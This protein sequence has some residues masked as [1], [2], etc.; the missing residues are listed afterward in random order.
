MLWLTGSGHEKNG[1][2]CIIRGL[3]RFDRLN[4]DAPLKRVAG[5][6]IPN[7]QNL[8]GTIQL[9][10]AARSLPPPSASP[11]SSTSR[12]SSLKGELGGGRSQS[13]GRRLEATETVAQLHIYGL[14]VFQSSTASV[15][16]GF[17]PI[18][19]NQIGITY[20]IEES[21][22]DSL[23]QRFTTLDE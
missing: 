19:T 10:L 3:V 5:L 21:E 13:A 12:H 20:V 11:T 18:F 8:S 17:H 7:N 16:V 9:D 1:R 6:Q 4:R 14:Y 22:T 15:P 23:L 2:V